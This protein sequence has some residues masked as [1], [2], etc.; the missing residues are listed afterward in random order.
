MTAVQRTVRGWHA[1]GFTQRQRSIP[2][3]VQYNFVPIQKI[4]EEQAVGSVRW[5]FLS[6]A[7]T[8]GEWI[9]IQCTQYCLTKAQSGGIS[10]SAR[11][12]NC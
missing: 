4:I 10:I 12:F 9:C 7:T 1:D 8:L 2:A 6:T 11:K 5:S 3:E